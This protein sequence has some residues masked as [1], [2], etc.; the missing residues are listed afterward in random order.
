MTGKMTIKASDVGFAVDM[1]LDGVCTADKLEMLH[2][3][4][5]GLDMSKFDLMLFCELERNG[6]FED[7]QQVAYCKT[8]EELEQMLHGETPKANEPA[9]LDDVMEML[10]TLT[11]QLGGK[12]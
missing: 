8:A 9:T 6:V 5:T 1:D 7:A 12:V 11:I 4:A 2:V 3:V 10:K